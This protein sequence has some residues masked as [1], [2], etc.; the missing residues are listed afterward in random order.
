MHNV[1]HD[2]DFLKETLASTIA[3][4]EFTAKLYKIFETVFAEGISQVCKAK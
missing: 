1:A 3:V 2:T 4:D